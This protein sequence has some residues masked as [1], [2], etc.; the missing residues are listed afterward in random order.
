MRHFSLALLGAL[1]LFAGCDRAA[2]GDPLAIDAKALT[3]AHAYWLEPGKLA[4]NAAPGDE[5]RLFVSPDGQL[6][7]NRQ[8]LTGGSF[9][10]LRRDGVVA[11]ELASRF[12]HLAG[13]ALH[14][15]PDELLEL[16]PDWLR[17]QS[18]IARFNT[19]GELLATTALQAAAALDTLYAHQQPLGVNFHGDV[20]HQQVP[21]LHLWAPTA[22]EVRLHLFADPLPDTPPAEVIAMQR[23]DRTGTWS[24]SGRGDWLYQYYL[25]E[26]KVFTRQTGRIERHLVTDPYSLGLSADSERS[27]IINL[28]AA[29]LKPT[30]WANLPK[31]AIRAPEDISI[32]ELHVRDFSIS[33]ATV[34]PALRGKFSAFAQADSAGIAHLRE[35]AADGLS[36]VHLLPTM[37]CAS[38]PERTEDQSRPLGLTG[39]PPNSDQPQARIGPLRDTDAFNWCYDPWHYTV[40]EGS[41]AT[42]PDGTARIVEFR[43]MVAGLNRSGLGVILDVV[44]NHTHSA[45]RSPR[46]VLDRIVPDYYHRLDAIGEIATST[47]CP[48]TATEHVMMER[49][50]LDSLVTWATQY[51]VDGFRFDLMGHHSRQSLERTRAVLD[52]LTVERDGVDGKAIYLYGEGWNFGEVANNARFEQATQAN[53]GRGTGIGTFND[54]MRDALRGGAHDDRGLEHVRTQGFIN[55]LFLDP[56][57]EHSGAADERDQLLHFSD[58]IRV[59]LAGSIADFSFIDRN[60]RR[61]TAADVDYNGQATGYTSDPQEAINYAAAHDNETLFDINQYKLPPG[62]SKAERIRAQNLANSVIALSQGIPFFHAGQE[63]LRSKSLDRNSFNSGDWFNPLDFSYQSNGW[64][65]GLPPHDQN[66]DN[67]PVAEELLLMDEPVMG[68]KHILA[69]RAHFGEMLRIRYSSHLFRLRGAS[70]IKHALKFHNTGPH[71][72]PGLIV[73]SLSSTQG[74]DIV[75]VFNAAPEARSF[76]FPTA[77]ATPFTLHPEQQRSR[78]PQVRVAAWDGAEQTFFTPGRTTAVFVRSID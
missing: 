4:W 12:P 77:G 56:N 2:V 67:W 69:A 66:A 78:D 18:A 65:R 35:L 20:G 31:P 37:D 76:A 62:A 70:D 64:G 6:A 5:L 3:E 36:H 19:E 32:Y 17:G 42:E 22:R 29:A 33:D 75:V 28:G 55:G 61:V 73:M 57:T 24:V 60:G 68:R 48:N 53:M 41:Y 47:C 43:E 59:G 51:R 50:M 45:G 49:L 72:V 27:Q 15:V 71:A 38:I 13:V 39:H 10:P 63:L 46:S 26:V 7:V 16:V 34:A 74:T 23:D 25:Y 14:R 58:Q 9:F 30:D 44:Y 21:S 1:A 54:R 40:P 52:A 8:G 11:G